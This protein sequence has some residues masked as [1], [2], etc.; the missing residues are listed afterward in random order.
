MLPVPGGIS[1][2]ESHHSENKTSTTSSSRTRVVHNIDEAPYS[3]IESVKHLSKSVPIGD[4]DFITTSPIK[5]IITPAKSLSGGLFQ[6]STANLTP[7]LISGYPVYDKNEGCVIYKFDLSGFSETEIQLTITVDRTLE[8]KASKETTDHL[9]KVYREFKREIQLEPEVDANLIKNL[10]YEGILTIK[11][12][13]PNRADGKG[14]IT[15]SHNLQA[16]SGF[17]EIY[18]DDGKLAK[19]TSDF[20]GYS[21]ENV[22]IVLSG[23]N[24]LKVHAQ[25]FDQSPTSKGTVLKEC[26]RQ[27]TL[28]D[29]VKSDQMKAIMSRDGILTV[30]FN[31]KSNKFDDRIYS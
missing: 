7:E 17:Q 16:P 30:E 12:P 26:T 3:T 20:R 6:K 14:S 5:S 31:A 24:V 4:D 18:N 11:I 27:Y 13:K 10:F 9:G 29:W 19:L 2:S 8:I 1:T 28:P 15:N 22:K 21:P 25:Q 23:N